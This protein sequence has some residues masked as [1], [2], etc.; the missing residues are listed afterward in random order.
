MT[1]G[2]CLCGAVEFAI[3]GP[4][5]DVTVCHCSVCRRLHGGAA[6]FSACA[7]ADLDLRQDS[8]LRWYAHG[9]AEYGFCAECG[10]RLFW[11]RQPLSTVSFNAA[12]IAQPTGLASTHHIWVG[13]AGDYE[14]L[15]TALPCHSESSDSPLAGG[16]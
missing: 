14:D 16:S 13:S 8:A 7:A 15:S 12:C 11:R 5:R 4:I 3:A 9:G 6:A 1:E 2:R 10:S